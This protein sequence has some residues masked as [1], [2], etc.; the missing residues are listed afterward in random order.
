MQLSA[1]AVTEEGALEALYQREHFPI[2]TTARLVDGEYADREAGLT[3]FTFDFDI[4]FNRPEWSVEH[5]Y[6]GVPHSVSTVGSRILAI[7]IAGYCAMHADTHE[8]GMMIADRAMFW[9][10]FDRYAGTPYAVR[11]FEGC[12]TGGRR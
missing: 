3:K 6:E 12:M 7:G 1:V 8:R 4:P 10:H 9:R 5:P 2:G 11:T